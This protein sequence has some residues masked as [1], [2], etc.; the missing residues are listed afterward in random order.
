MPSKRPADRSERSAEHGNRPTDRTRYVSRRDVLGSLAAVGSIAIAG[1]SSLRSLLSP[2]PVWRR[3]IPNAAAAGPLTVGGD[4]VFVGA[5]DKALYGLHREDGSTVLRFETGGPIESRPAVSADGQTAHVHSTDGDL[6]TVDNTG[7]LRWSDEG[8][9]DRSRIVRRGSLLVRLTFDSPDDTMTG[10]DAMGG[11][12]RFERPVATYRLNGLLDES[13]VVPEP[14]SEVET[15]VT[16]LSTTDGTVQWA[17]D[18]SSSYPGVRADTNLVITIR[19]SRVSAYEPSDGRTRWETPI[20]NPGY[21]TELGP[22]VYLTLDESNSNQELVALDRKTGSR[23]WTQSAG[24]DIRAIE[25]TTDAVFVGSRVDDPDG[26]ILGRID[27]FEL[28][29]TRRWHTVTELPSV[30]HIVVIGS[31]VVLVSDRAFTVVDAE[32]G[33]ERWT[34]EP[35]SYSRL[36]VHAAEQSLFVSYLDDGAVA[37]FEID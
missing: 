1:C 14:V 2:D 15:R 31:A 18:P 21:L 6:Y 28:D 27:C 19:E 23:R 34:H 8:R 12:T 4:R 20:G 29:G 17:T 35:D 10:F 11:E 24:L 37:R 32:T 13:L 26:G 33:T 9:F 22:H 16:A 3:D 7:E 36:S 30:E 5:Q 25:P